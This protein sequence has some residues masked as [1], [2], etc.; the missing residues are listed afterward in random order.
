MADDEAL[1]ERLA[2]AVRAH[3]GLT[4]Y[5][6]AIL[7]D[8][9]EDQLE[10]AISRLIR[11][12]RLTDRTQRASVRLYAPKILIDAESATYRIRPGM[13]AWEVL[14]LAS[15]HPNGITPADVAALTRMTRGYAYKM[16]L[17]LEADRLLTRCR[18]ERRWKVNQIGRALLAREQ[19]EG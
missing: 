10:Q 5:R 3:P 14:V 18:N 9:H 13:R 2:D 15:A 11:E 16:M 4:R 19:P 7:L 1:A 17:R 6:L 12:G 8:V